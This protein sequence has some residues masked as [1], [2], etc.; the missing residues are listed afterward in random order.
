MPLHFHLKQQ[1]AVPLEAEVLSPDAVSG[2]SNAEIRAL[3]V[4]HGKRQVPL[5]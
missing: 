3:I 5:E 2:L 1:P 4:Y